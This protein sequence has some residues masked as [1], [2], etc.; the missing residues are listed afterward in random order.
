[1]APQCFAKYLGFTLQTY[2]GV[3]FELNSFLLDYKMGARW[4]ERAH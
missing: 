4:I 1:M 3:T 2:R